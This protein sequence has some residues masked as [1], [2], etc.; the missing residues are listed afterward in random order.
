MED[1]CNF[2]LFTA[3]ACIFAFAYAEF[4]SMV[5]SGSAYVFLCCLAQRLVA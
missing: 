2:L 5:V 1:C 4:A 3:L